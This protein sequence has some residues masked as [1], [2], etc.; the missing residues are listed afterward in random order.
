MSRFSSQAPSRFFTVRLVTSLGL[1][2]VLSQFLRSSNAVLAPELSHD[3]GISAEA[4]G[5]LTGAY[6]LAFAAVQIPIGILLDRFGPRRVIS[7]MLMFAV[8]GC[9]VFARAES[10]ME[11]IAGRILMGL[12]CAS[13]LM[14]ALV[15]YAR[16][17]APERFAFF[18]AVQLGIGNTGI[19][20]ATSPLA[21]AVEG[22]GWRHSIASIGLYA[23]LLAVLVLALVRDAPDDHPVLSHPQ[24]S[25]KDSFR[26]V[27]AILGNRALWPL[28]PLICTGY[29]AVASVSAL[30]GGPYLAD[31]HGLGI[32]ARGNLLLIMA[33][34]SIFGSLAYAP[35]D[36]RFGTRKRIVVAGCL[37]NVAAFVCLAVIDRPSLGLVAALFVGLTGGVGY[38]SV[39]TAHARA[40]YPDH[41]VGRGMTLANMG[42]MMGVAVLQSLTG[43]VLAACS[44]VG[45]AAGE[46]AYQAVFGLLAGVLLVTLL[47]YLRGK[48]IPPGREAEFSPRNIYPAGETAP[49]PRSLSAE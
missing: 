27:A 17:Y 10:L 49:P 13:I 6:F 11:L 14:G 33:L 9:F 47:I 37:M 29:G 43:A 1:A 24:E 30:W 36:R 15:V 7:I 4:L 5:I 21:A 20:L 38:M 41:L 16:W 18:T 2:Y 34:G 39:L 44:I 28:L 8:A 12:G 31:V 45:G 26:G 23:L 42:N 40:L 25:F 22:I 32:Q 48:D 35:L 19:L 46:A 3:L